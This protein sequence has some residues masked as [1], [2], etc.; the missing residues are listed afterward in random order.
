MKVRA[1]QRLR[2][3]SYQANATK[4]PLGE[5]YYTPASERTLVN[6][7]RLASKQTITHASATEHEK[8]DQSQHVP[9]SAV[10]L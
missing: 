4:L 3:S 10:L 9:Q 1:T 2:E 7:L 6:E 5:L 8:N